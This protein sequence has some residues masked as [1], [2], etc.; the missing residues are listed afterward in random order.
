MFFSDPHVGLPASQCGLH[1]LVPQ[2]HGKASPTINPFKLF[3]R[4][5][6]NLLI[7]PIHKEKQ[8]IF[9]PDKMLLICQQS[10]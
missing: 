6:A 3:L 10:T 8:K 7:P 1:H 5:A 2:Q 9:N 4:A